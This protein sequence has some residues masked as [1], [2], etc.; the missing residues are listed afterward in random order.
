MS[1][2][3]ALQSLLVLSLIS[4]VAFAKNKKVS[5][6]KLLSD[7]HHG[8][9]PRLKA[10]KNLPQNFGGDAP[11]IGTDYP[12]QYSRVALRLAISD[13]RHFQGVM[14]DII[15]PLEKMLSVSS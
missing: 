6:D 14:R 10:M 7:L 11:K 12:E 4:T 15:Y 2:V 5:P 3:K 1:M 13:E 9:T 8:T